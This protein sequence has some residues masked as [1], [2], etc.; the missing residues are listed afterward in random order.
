MKTLR[1]TS[2]I[3]LALC[4]LR[5]PII[6]TL[7]QRGQFTAEDVGLTSF[8]MAF[9]ALGLMPNGFVKILAPAFYAHQNTATP[10]RVGA[11]AFVIHIPLSIGLAWWMGHGG[12]ALST[13]I[14]AA[15]NAFGLLYLLRRREGPGWLRPLAASFGRTLGAA[16]V[17]GL[18][19]IWMLDWADFPA[20]TGLG[21]RAGAL[22]LLV[23]TG[24]A[25][26][27]LAARLLGARE[28]GQIWADL[29]G[30]GA[31]R[32]SEGR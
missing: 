27:L 21:A 5:R 30:R 19:L 9:Y 31:S 7:F 3:T 28:G 1:T 23:A 26:Y 32:H 13:S 15:V 4:L 6:A 20:R 12:I 22:A 25:V 29:R 8:A 11:F 17:M 14:A 2:L 24:V 18:A 16:L 10:V